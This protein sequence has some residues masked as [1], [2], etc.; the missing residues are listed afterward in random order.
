MGKTPISATAGRRLTTDGTRPSGTN[1][2]MALM[3]PTFAGCARSGLAWQADVGRSTVLY[4]DGRNDGRLPF[5][6]FF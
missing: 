3:L 1:G 2:S 4:R 6:V 5:R